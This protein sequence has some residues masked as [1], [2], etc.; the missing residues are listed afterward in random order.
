MK[1]IFGLILAYLHIPI[2]I[3]LRLCIRK[4]HVVVNARFLQRVELPSAERCVERCIENMRFCLAAQFSMGKTKSLGM[5]TL[6]T[7]TAMQADDS[8]MPEENLDPVS[9]VYE[10]A[11]KCPSPFS[12]GD[13]THRISR[14]HRMAL[15]G[16]DEKIMKGKI[17]L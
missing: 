12:S 8:V 3:S 16:G 1:L 14:L 9:T 2:V 7:A 10:I 17:V 4:H 6:F 5:C 11:Q 15:E 13:M